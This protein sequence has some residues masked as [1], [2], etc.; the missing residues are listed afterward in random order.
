MSITDPIADMLTVVRNA[1]QAKKAQTVVRNS[2]MAREI[3]GILKAEGMIKDFRVL[4]TDVQG[5]IR[6]YLRY[7]PGGKPV[8]TGLQRASKPGLRVYRG[9][10]KLPKVLSG[11]GTSIISTSKGV[12]TSQEARKQKLGGEVLCYAW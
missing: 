8:L 7:T 12:M 5:A 1:I 2:K 11:L 4:E 9:C 6:V 3:L 10:D